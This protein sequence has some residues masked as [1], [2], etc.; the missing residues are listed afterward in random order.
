MHNIEHLIKSHPHNPDDADSFCLIDAIK[1]AN[2]MVWWTIL[3]LLRC[4]KR[5]PKTHPKLFCQHQQTGVCTDFIPSL[6]LPADAQTFCSEKESLF[7]TLKSFKERLTTGRRPAPSATIQ[8]TKQQ[9]SIST[10]HTC[11]MQSAD[12]S[13]CYHS[14]IFGEKN[15]NCADIW[16][17][18]WVNNSKL[19]IFLISSKRFDLY[20]WGSKSD[21]FIFILSLKTLKRNGV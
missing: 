14:W 16:A 5:K 4:R 1:K 6:L 11:V 9:I 2:G 18:I 3:F 20:V 15:E 17:D 12:R 19:N 10:S 8:P 13:F 21:A 7:V